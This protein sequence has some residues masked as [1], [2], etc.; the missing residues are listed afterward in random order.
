MAKQRLKILFRCPTNHRGEGTFA[1]KVSL[2]QE[3]GDKAVVV[4]R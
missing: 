4:R 3:T 2:E 1:K